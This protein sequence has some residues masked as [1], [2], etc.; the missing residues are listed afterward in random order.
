MQGRVSSRK[1]TATFQ[2][3]PHRSSRKNGRWG[4]VNVPIDAGQREFPTSGSDYDGD[5]GQMCDWNLRPRMMF[6]RLGMIRGGR[7]PRSVG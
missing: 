4:D 1:F 5:L 6:V 7:K 3:N 2:G